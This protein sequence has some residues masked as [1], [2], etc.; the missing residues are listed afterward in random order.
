MNIFKKFI[1]NRGSSL[2]QTT[3]FLPFYALPFVPNPKT[4]PSYREMFTVSWK[5][6]FA[7]FF[8]F[9]F[10][11]QIHRWQHFIAPL[12]YSINDVI[13]DVSLFIARLS[14]VFTVV[15]QSGSSLVP[16][17]YKYKPTLRV[18]SNLLQGQNQI[19]FVKLMII[20][21]ISLTLLLGAGHTQ[22]PSTTLYRVSFHDFPLLS[23][24]LSFILF[25][26]PVNLPLFLVL[27]GFR[28]IVLLVILMLSFLSICPIYRH[29]LCPLYQILSCSF[30]YLFISYLVTPFY[31][32]QLAKWIHFFKGV[33]I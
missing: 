19:L 18:I 6:S 3:E 27:W 20:I 10:S 13:L 26:V 14:D 21:I 11:F 29:L 1:E 32:K 15:S 8:S 17:Y 30:P 16:Y 28:S 23:R 4:H 7:V 31:P 25:H 2:S 22:T 5:L 24:Y 9:F 12:N 33:P